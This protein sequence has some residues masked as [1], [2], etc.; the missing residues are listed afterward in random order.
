ME[1]PPHPMRLGS[2]EQDYYVREPGQA[3][4]GDAVDGIRVA[5]AQA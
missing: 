5:G 1:A 3:E 4:T 2:D